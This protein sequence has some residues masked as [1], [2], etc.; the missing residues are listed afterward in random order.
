MGAQFAVETYCFDSLEEA[1]AHFHR[2]GGVD[3]WCAMPQAGVSIFSKE[4]TPCSSA[5]VL[6]N[7]ANG[8]SAPQVGMHVTIPMPGNA[9]SLNVAQAATLF[10]FEAVR[11]TVV[12]H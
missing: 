6:G 8:I 12:F 10:I 9:E 2:L 3:V 11:R 1:V 4:F 7:E 5:V